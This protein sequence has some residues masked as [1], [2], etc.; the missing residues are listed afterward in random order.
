MSAGIAHCRQVVDLAPLLQQTQVLL[1]QRQLGVAQVQ[2]QSG[3][4]RTQ[5]LIK[6]CGGHAAILSGAPSAR[7]HW[8]AGAAALLLEVDQ[9]QRNGGRR[10]AEMREASP[11]FPAG[12]GPGSGAPRNSAP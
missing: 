2:P 6:F 9:Q 1:Q 11:G 3:A 8:Q 5:R 10:D 12:G 7:A 4:A